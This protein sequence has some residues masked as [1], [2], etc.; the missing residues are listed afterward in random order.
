MGNDFT[1]GLSYATKLLY[2]EALMKIYWDANV[3]DIGSKCG[4]QG[5]SHLSG[6]ML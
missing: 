1:R 6:K 5:E 4:Y 3:K 2:Q